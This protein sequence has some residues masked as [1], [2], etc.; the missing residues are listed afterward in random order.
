MWQKFCIPVFL[1]A[2]LVLL[3]SP[4]ARG[5]G[6]PFDQEFKTSGGF[7]IGLTDDWREVPTDV[8]KAVN[9][10]MNAMTKIPFEWQYAYQLKDAD[11][12]LAYPYI[13][14]KFIPGRKSEQAFKKELVDKYGLKTAT[15]DASKK[16]VDNLFNT[17]LGE[18]GYDEASKTGHF[19]VQENVTGIG[20][21]VGY[22][23]IRLTD[24]GAI[25]FSAYCLDSQKEE[26]VPFFKTAATHIQ[27]A[28]G[29][30][31]KPRA[32]DGIPILENIDFTKVSNSALVGGI[33]GGLA[34][35][36]LVLVRRKKKA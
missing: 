21:I 5:A 20:K 11:H 25:Q 4:S 23:A 17:S 13:L 7:S 35:L 8:L 29:M 27:V 28:D 1:G 15:E 33:A 14:V 34:G 22:T 6:K 2:W 32:L 12:W 36:I 24:K 26:M 18:T 19:I 10:K 16:A 9:E 31:Y 30:A 3:S